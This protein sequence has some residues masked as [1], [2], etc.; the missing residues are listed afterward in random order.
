[1]FI[2]P[3]LQT[4]R[5]CMGEETTIGMVIH[6]KERVYI[7]DIGAS[8]HMMDYLFWIIRRE[9]FRQSIKLLEFQTANAIV[10][11]DTQAKVYIKE[12]GVD[13]FVRSWWQILHQ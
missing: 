5:L 4:L 3:N 11:S 8:L 1:M 10:V 12:F 9:I 13:L 2:K 7:V 6:S